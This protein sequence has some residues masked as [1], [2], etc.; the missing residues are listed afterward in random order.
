MQ[1]QLLVGTFRFF[2][3][4]SLNY[5]RDYNLVQKQ[6][7][8]DKCLLRKSKWFSY[9]FTYKETSVFPETY[10][11]SKPCFSRNC[12]ALSEKFENPAE[13]HIFILLQYK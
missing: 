4:I 11:D 12:I 7:M 3:L 2:S 6:N 13:T 10:W 9:K 1:L 5:C 8:Q